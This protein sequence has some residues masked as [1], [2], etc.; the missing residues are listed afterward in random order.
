M[1]FRLSKFASK[2]LRA[3]AFG[4]ASFLPTPSR[5]LLDAKPVVDTPDR[6]DEIEIDTVCMAAPVNH[7]L[8]ARYTGMRVGL[9]EQISAMTHARGKGRNYLNMCFGAAREATERFIAARTRDV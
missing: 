6:I 8:E 4:I 3:M 7:E 5:P 9:D 2:S 1:S